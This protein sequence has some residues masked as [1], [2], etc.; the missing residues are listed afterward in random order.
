MKTEGQKFKARKGSALCVTLVTSGILSVVLGSYL[1]LLNAHDQLVERSQ[2]WNSALSVAEAGVEEAMAHLNSGV[3]TNNLAVNTWTSFGSASVGKTNYL[4]TS[5]YVVSIQTTVSNPLIVAT[6]YVPP[7]GDGPT[8]TRTLQVSTRQQPGVGAAAAVIVKGGVNFGG[9]KI[10][11]DSFDSSNTN[12]STGG[13]YDPNKRRAHGDII[14]TSLATNA[15]YIGDS[16]VAGTIHTKPGTPVG[17]DTKTNQAS[18]LVGDLNYMTNN[19]YGIQAGHAVQDAS[20]NFTDVTLPSV[21]WMPPVALKPQFKTNGVSY[22]YVLDNSMPWSFTSLSQSIYVKSPN[23]VVYVSGSL[24]MGS[25]TAIYIAPGASLTLYVGGASASIGGQGVINDSGVA[26]NF[27]YY[28]LP[29]NTSL[30]IQANAG[31]TGRIIAP[32]ADVTLGGGGSTPYDYS[33]QL[34]ANSLNLNGHYSIHYDEAL[35]TL[36][37]TN[38]PGIYVAASWN[39]L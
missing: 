24:N 17:V 12:Y 11:V 19:V 21:T 32:Q 36:S 15:V 10:M 38:A 29:S 27:T 18:Y 20:Y 13:L 28:G 30:G 39:E 31:F 6:A 37:G 1:T 26:P 22:P 33:G 34:V 4:G 9:N 5:Y 25:G 7:P 16:D 3:S 14:T 8:L 23:T 2:G 35:G